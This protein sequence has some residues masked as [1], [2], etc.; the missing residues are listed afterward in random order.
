MIKTLTLAALLGATASSHATIEPTFK[1]WHNME[2]NEV[3]R[4]PM[5]TS[6]FAYENEILALKGSPELSK[7][8][9][10]LNGKWK[11]KGVENAT[12]RPTDFFLPSYNDESWGEM[13]VPGIWELNGFGDPVYVNIGFAWRGHFKNDPPYVPL[14]HNR[15]GSY[16]RVIT[17]P[18]NWKNKQVIAHFGSATSNIYLWVNGKFVGYAEDAKAAAEFDIT[19]YMKQ[20]DNLIAFQV[21]RWSDGSYCEDQDFWRLSGIARNSFLFAKDKDTHLNDI[22]ITPALKN[23]YNDGV[24]TIQHNATPSSWVS[25]ELTDAKGNTVYSTVAN[26]TS[27]CFDVP[28]AHKWTAETPYLYTLI[29][30]VYKA[31]KTKNTPSF[32]ALSAQKPVEVTTQK[33]GFRSVEIKN[34]QVLVNGKPILIKGANRHEID[35]DGGYVVNKERMVEDIKLMKRFNINAVRTCHYPDDPMWYDLCDEYGIYVCAEANQESHGFYYNEDAI[36]RTPL[37]AKQILERNQHNVQ[38]NFNH[39]S[40]IFWSLGNE[41]ADGPNFTTAYNWIKTQD[42]SRPVQYERAIKGINTDVFCPMYRTQKEMEEYAISNAQEDQR[43]LIQCEYSHAMGN[44]SGGFKEYWEVIRR[45]PKLQGGFIWDFV[46]QGLRMKDRTGKEYY[47]YGGDFNTYDPSD[48]NFNCNG[49][50]SPDRIP[51]PQTYEVGYWY[52]NVWVKPV[53]LSQGKIEVFNEYFFK[54]LSNYYLTWQLV[55]EGKT[56]QEGVIENLD[57]EPQQ[58]KQYTLSLQPTPHIKGETFLNVQIKL[59][60]DEP[61]MS[62]GQVVAYDQF[63][64]KAGSIDKNDVFAAIDNICTSKKN[65]TIKM[66]KDKTNGTITLSNA[67]FNLTFDGKTGFI[68]RYNISGCDMIAK[69][70]TLKPNFWRAPTDNDMGAEVQKDNAIWRNPTFSLLTLKAENVKPANKKD[71]PS[72]R[73]TALYDV[74]EVYVALTLT[75]DINIDGQVNVEQKMEVQGD[76]NIPDLLR[77]GMVMDMPN[78]FNKSVFYGRGPVEN[79]SDRKQSQLIGVYTQTV[80]EQYYPYIRPQETGLKTDIRYWKQLQDGCYG[81][82]VVPQEPCSMS[83]LHYTVSSLDNGLEKTQR[84]GSLVEKSPLTHLYIDAIQAGV[85][86][87]DS[88]SKKAIALEPYRVHYQ[89]R[90]FRFTLGACTD[91][92]P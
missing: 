76:K 50:M 79:Y 87:I 7:N 80:D 19:P 27:T 78:T 49:L 1:E 57:V 32:H 38:V 42:L 73:I 53:M 25:Y 71:L 74:P 67:Y 46:D 13:P 69:G 62:K 5:H 92:K 35:P 58:A 10:S 88:W 6:F 60:D 43:P 8:Y 63:A 21:Y 54:D 81:L 90:T 83:A 11:F 33:V 68:S 77:F 55:S 28:N 41:T 3:N 44:S 66:Q 23:N 18:D 59:K 36:S 40:I 84:H 51:N 14:T 24:L 47:A 31:T 30:R 86:G 22:R 82:A 34:S 48:N 91:K 9:L 56:L 15:V 20:G 4:F 75:Y 72:V 61:L 45:Y 16:R 2:V 85:G 64:I 52:Q 37:F 89:N 26:N 17:L 39:P 70:G 65:A 12:E 29:T